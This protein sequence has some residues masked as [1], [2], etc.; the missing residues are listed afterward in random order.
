MSLEIYAN[1][2]GRYARYLP[3]EPGPL[4]EESTFTV[5]DAQ[6]EALWMAIQ[7]HD[8]FSLEPSYTARHI[9]DGSMAI[10]S[11][12][13]QGF[14]HHVEMEN[15]SVPRFESL[16]EAINQITPEGKDLP[17]TATIPGE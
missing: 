7:F 16:L 11:V 10:L 13:A 14:T 1:G 2:E 15:S 5:S 8:F 6:L 17:Y 9:N 12:T 3:S 4:L